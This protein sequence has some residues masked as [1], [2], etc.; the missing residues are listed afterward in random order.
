MEAD[1]EKRGLIVFA[2]ARV[3]SKAELA[4]PPY[5]AQP[6]TTKGVA[7]GRR[8]LLPPPPHPRFLPNLHDE[9]QPRH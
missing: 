4:N 1:D 6:V 8:A 7:A 9:V 5:G 2:Q 3:T